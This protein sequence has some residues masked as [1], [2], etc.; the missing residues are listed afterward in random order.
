M[1]VTE[2]VRIWNAQ[3]G[4]WQTVTVEVTPEPVRHGRRRRATVRRGAPRDLSGL[5]DNS[6][7]A[8]WWRDTAFAPGDPLADMRTWVKPATTRTHRAAVVMPADAGSV[9]A[10]KASDRLDT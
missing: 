4:E 3:A 1:I 2:P 10:R 7:I 8:P 9:T 5:S 6:P